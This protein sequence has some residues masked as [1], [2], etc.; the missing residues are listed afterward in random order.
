[1]QGFE[2]GRVRFVRLT[3]VPERL[4]TAQMS[5]ARLAEHLPLLTGPWTEAQTRALV[6]EKERHWT[7]DG[8]GHCGI[9]VGDR[10]AGWGGFQKE[11]P[12]WD[13]G[14]VLCADQFGRGAEI[15]RA[16]LEFARSDPRLR[17]V[18]FLLPMSRK[19]LRALDRLGARQVGLVQLSGEQFRKF[20]LHV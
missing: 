4:I 14:L 12:E 16:A 15:T 11:G 2:A 5:D 10:Y 3:Q 1:M 17:T 7:R 8:L 9:Y 6:A 20:V 18:T 13:Y 19:H